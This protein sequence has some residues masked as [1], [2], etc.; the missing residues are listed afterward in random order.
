MG[1]A[2]IGGSAKATCWGA[3]GCGAAAAATCCGAVRRGRRG[4]CHGAIRA[5]D[6]R[7][8]PAR[9]AIGIVDRRYRRRHWGGAWH[10]RHGK[11]FLPRHDALGLRLIS[12]LKAF[13]YQLVLVRKFLA[14]SLLWRLFHGAAVSLDDGRLTAAHGSAAL[15]IGEGES[16]AERDGAEQGAAD[17]VDAAAL[18]AEF[19]RR[20]GLR[21]ARSHEL[22]F[23]EKVGVALVA[24]V[25]I[26]RRVLRRHLVW[27]LRA[28]E[29]DLRRLVVDRHRRLAEPDATAEDAGRPTA[30]APPAKGNRGR[31][32]NRVLTDLRTTPDRLR[33]R[34]ERSHR[35]DAGTH[36]RQR[37]HDARAP[38]R[39]PAR[40]SPPGNLHLGRKRL[41]SWHP[42]RTNRRSSHRHNSCRCISARS[43][44]GV[45]RP[46]PGRSG[47]G[48]PRPGRSARGWLWLVRRLGRNWACLA[49]SGTARL[50][51]WLRL[52]AL[53][54]VGL[55]GL[56]LIALLRLIIL[57]RLRLIALRLGLIGLLG[58]EGIWEVWCGVASRRGA[59]SAILVRI[60]RYAGLY[61]LPCIGSKV[62]LGRF[63]RLRLR[64]RSSRDGLVGGHLRKNRPTAGSE[65]RALS[66]HWLA[67]SA[68]SRSHKGILAPMSCVCVRGPGLIALG[69]DAPKTVGEIGLK[70]KGGTDVVPVPLIVHGHG[71]SPEP[72]PPPR[73][74]LNASR[75][76]P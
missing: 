37:R 13:V 6:H 46:R 65:N 49:R 40:P 56:R 34:R 22:A 36:A 33:C 51:G 54:R 8:H 57:L 2:G 18:Q 35:R 50:G 38:R 21:L 70:L 75:A 26:L 55:L 73:L 71:T 58:R 62:R 41:G 44:S 42:G 27:I 20:L 59:R 69:A 61:A 72:S 5:D 31:P 25:E 45:A 68:W 11:L 67:R 30:Y 52:V 1:G 43:S 28:A 24:L 76:L 47:L 74:S 12:I 29:R 10:R 7:L 19:A 63:R 15:L 3:A 4:F 16:S 39:N 9:A 66:R 32:D 60:A 14:T 23:I 17:H 53:P 64:L 48:S